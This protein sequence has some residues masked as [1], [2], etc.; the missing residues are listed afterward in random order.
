M[1]MDRAAF[2]AEGNLFVPGATSLPQWL[3]G[4]SLAD[5]GPN[6][7]WIP[8]NGVVPSFRHPDLAHRERGREENG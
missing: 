2:D 6:T 3:P 5:S 8:L 1:G 7:G 4:K